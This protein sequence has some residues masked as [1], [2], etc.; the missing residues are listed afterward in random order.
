MK[1]I[2]L[3]LN[4]DH[5]LEEKGNFLY[6]WWECKLVQPLWRT[7]WRLL[8]KLKIVTIWSS[9]PTPGHTSRESTNLKRCVHPCVHSNTIHNSQDME[10]TSM[11]V[12]RWMDEEDVAR[13][14]HGILLR[15][16]K[17]NSATC[18]D[19]DRA[20]DYHT[21][22]GEPERER[23]ILYDITYM[24]NLKSDTN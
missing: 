20:R 1:F 4:I 8:K 24:Q 23:Q 12:E 18:S 15:H 13:I 5:T 21:K 9:N 6:D 11:S 10:T 16:R 2:W 17:W 14:Y 22:P 7:V 3:K 19:M